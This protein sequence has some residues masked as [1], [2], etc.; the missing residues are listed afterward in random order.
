MIFDSPFYWNKTH[1]GQEPIKKIVKIETKFLKFLNL[2]SLFFDY[3]GE[4]DF[5]I[6]ME[7]QSYSMWRKL[8]G[9]RK[10]KT[11]QHAEF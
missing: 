8:Y 3:I 11:I 10:H 7:N 6:K 9:T 2:S 4:I 5:K 1:Y